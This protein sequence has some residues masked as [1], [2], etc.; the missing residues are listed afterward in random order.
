MFCAMTFEYYDY[1]YLCPMQQQRKAYLYAITTILLWATVGSAFK[2][3][4]KHLN[5]I[6]LLF[7]ATFVSL[8]AIWSVLIIQ[9]KTGFFRKVSGKDIAHSAL[10]GFFNPFIYYLVLFKAYSIL[11]A[12]EAV[13]LNYV[14]P[15]MLVLLSI[16]FLKQPIGWKSILA[17]C[18]SFIGT[19][20][21]ATGGQ[22]FDFHLTNPLGVL[23]ALGSACI[24]ALYWIF[25]VKDKRE[26]V[27]KLFLNFAFGSIYILIYTLATGNFKI[28]DAKGFL[29]VTYIGFFEMGFTFIFWLKALKFSSTT[30]KVTN[31]I[32]IAPFLSLLIVSMVVGEKIMISTLAGLFFIVSGIIMQ[33]Y[34][35]D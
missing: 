6:Q 7:Y 18:V 22:I 14:W 8:F 10:L 32:Y 25:N 13:A 24:W 27:S 16:P 15:V 5:Y 9:R 23:L 21:I 17:I 20:L 26:E 19:L 31:L 1:A 34:I 28:P 12:Q 4:L 11:Q 29:G 33:Q 3:T 2:L 35:R 30:A